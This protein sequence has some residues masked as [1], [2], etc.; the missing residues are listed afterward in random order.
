MSNKFKIAMMMCLILVSSSAG[1]FARSLDEEKQS[2]RGYLKTIDAKITKY[3]AQGNLMKVRQLQTEKRSVLDR[4]EAMQQNVSSDNSETADMSADMING[5]S[6]E[7]VREDMNKAIAELKGQL[8][9]VKNDNGDAKIGGV[10]RFDW[11]KG[12]NNNTS[13]P[14]N[15]FDISRAYLDFKKKLGA[16]ASVRVTLDVARISGASAQNLFDYL[17]Y[18]YVD[19]PVDIPSS[20]QAIP[21][22]L[23]AKVGLQQT[24]WIDWSGKIW[25]FENILKAYSDIN[26]NS[27]GSSSDFGLGATGKFSLPA[28]PEIEYHATALNGQGYAKAEA[29]SAKDV[30]IRLNSDIAQ[31]DAGTVVLGGYV[32]VK[33]GLFSNSTTHQ[34]T[35]SGLLLGLKNADYGNVYFEYQNDQKSNKPVNGYSIGGFIYPTKAI[36]PGGFLARYDMY[37]TDTNASNNE[38]KTTVFGAFY[39][40]GKDVTV[41]VDITSIQ[42]GSGTENKTL[43]LRSQTVF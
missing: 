6:V 41:S 40:W 39:D 20:M 38:T 14:Y 23:T 33:N 32:G 9:S 31:T 29:D 2:V 19:L 18:A 36:V 42:T 24:C 1:V 16:G 8:D 22:S 12:L 26:K 21:F 17:K 28:M 7:D 43:A 25:R 34:S 13:V 35:Q 11:T 10:I 5:S 4:W 3:K 37:D 15:K 30:A 27:I